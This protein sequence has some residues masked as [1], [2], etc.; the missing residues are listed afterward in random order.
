MEKVDSVIKELMGQC[1]LPHRIFGLEPP[2][3]DIYFCRTQ[4]PNREVERQRWW[5]I[6]AFQ[7]YTNLWWFLA[8]LR[9]CPGTGAAASRRTNERVIQTTRQTDRQHCLRIR[10]FTVFFFQNPKNVTFYV[11]WKCHVKKRKNVESLMQVSCTQYQT[12][13]KLG[14]FRNVDF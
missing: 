13:T 7:V 8:I 6:D 4:I 12:T 9:I 5:V 3:T 11:F 1:P 14:T 10:F 2:L